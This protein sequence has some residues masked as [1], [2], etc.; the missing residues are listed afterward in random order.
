QMAA[1]LLAGTDLRNASA[2][3]MAIY[4][5]KDVIAVDQDPLGRQGVEVSSTGGLD[6]LAKPLSNGDVAVTLF[7]ENASAA[8]ISTT[9][10]A[11]GLPS[12]SSYT[13]NDLWA[14]SSTT[15]NG[16]TFSASV[17]AHGVVMYRVTANGATSPSASASAS[18]SPSASRSASPSP[19][20]SATPSSSP[21]AS[22][23]RSASASASPTGSTFCHVTYST[24]SQWAGGFT[25]NVTIADTGTSTINGW[26]LAFAFPGDQKVTNAWSATVSQSGAT[27]T[28]ANLSYNGSLSP[29]ASTSFG[30]QGTW[31]NSDAVPTHFTL[32]GT[33]CG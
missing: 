28:A 19:S 27:V 33:A 31:T 22:P 15:T 16:S 7:N 32:N 18:A 1:P 26:T 8:T 6:V 9:A 4:L 20:A 17:P 5:N 3:T 10:A 25:A 21:S 29:G 24:Q 12:A 2:A 30:F 13:L 14:H 11:V 23:S